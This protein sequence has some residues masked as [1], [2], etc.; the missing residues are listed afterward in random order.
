MQ[1]S[2]V[3]SRDFSW[4]FPRGVHLIPSNISHVIIHRNSLKYA[5]YQSPQYTRTGSVWG[6]VVVAFSEENKVRWLIQFVPSRMLQEE[7]HPSRGWR[8]GGRI[9]R[10]SPWLCLD[11][12]DIV[13]LVYRCVNGLTL[14]S[15]RMN[16]LPATVL[17]LSFCHHSPNAL[18]FIVCSAILIPP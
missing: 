3:K 2:H 12:F 5:L 15:L 10:R 9:S 13:V 18:A 11:P 4:K 17:F 7:R 14:L 6:I 1:D 16:T 8:N